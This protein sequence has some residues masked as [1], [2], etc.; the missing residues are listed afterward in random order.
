MK[1]AVITTIHVEDAGETYEET[2]VWLFDSEEIATIWVDAVQGVKFPPS[3]EFLM[4]NGKDPVS[5]VTLADR[6][7]EH[8]PA[9]R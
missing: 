5:I 7:W 3:T 2:D 4:M 9:P 6:Y 8:H 1:Y